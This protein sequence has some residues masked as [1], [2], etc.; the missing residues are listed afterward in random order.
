MK[1]VTNSHGGLGALLRREREAKGL[2]LEEM[3]HR[4]RIQRAHLDAIEREDYKALP[5]GPFVK[6]FVTAYG[7]ALG[8]KPE[9]LVPL[10]PEVD[11]GPPPHTTA[12]AANN[13]YGPELELRELPVGGR[14]RSGSGLILVGGL[15]LAVVIGGVL[16]QNPKVQEM[17]DLKSWAKKEL[18][19]DAARSGAVKPAATVTSPSKST[20]TASPGTVPAAGSSA[21][22][23]KAGDKVSEKP[24]D[25]SGTT[26]V[27]AKPGDPAIATAPA[28][29]EGTA[30]TR[31][32]AAPAATG[33]LQ[34]LSTF[35]SEVDQQTYDVYTDPANKGRE[36]SVFVSANS[37]SYLKVMTTPSNLNPTFEGVLL[38]GEKKTFNATGDIWLV[39]GNA[40]GITVTFNGQP[41]G[42]LGKYGERKGL[43]FRLRASD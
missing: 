10:I 27:E 36:Q 8:I 14:P 28:T 24:G 30:P 26:A 9:S 20:T 31:T 15:V 32:E 2:S 5:A 23:E 43:G 12:L 6:G 41:L 22:G 1:E 42:E 21:A 18:Q 4:T 7:K 3:A 19:E 11:H 40:A 16:W 13:Q 33:T 35:V 38:Q 25:T 34:R 29:K 37:K 39:V 17:L